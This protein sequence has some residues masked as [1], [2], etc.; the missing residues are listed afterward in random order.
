[1]QAVLA[2]FNFFAM[3]IDSLLPKYFD[4]GTSKFTIVTRF[5]FITGATNKLPEIKQKR[6]PVK[7][8]KLSGFTSGVICSDTV[9]ENEKA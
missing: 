7:R 2:A 5:R 4:C 3:F 9:Q 8:I 6:S 1:L